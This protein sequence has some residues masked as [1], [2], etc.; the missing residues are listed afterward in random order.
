MLISYNG[1]VELVAAGVVTDVKPEHIN[2]TSIDLVL[3]HSFLRESTCKTVAVDGQGI[4]YPAVNLGMRESPRMLETHL[5]EGYGMDMQPG[6]FILAHTANRFNLPNNISAEFSLKSSMA[7]AGLE[8]LLA[9]WIDPGFHDSVLTLELKNNLRNHT[10]VLVP[11]M[12]IGQ[13]K[14]FQHEPVPESA[15]YAARGRYNGDDTVKGIKP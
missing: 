2:A 15:S 5:G 6:E 10:L 4:I 13:V 1:L 9:G 14:F 11:G 8:H 3:G 12:L 7:R